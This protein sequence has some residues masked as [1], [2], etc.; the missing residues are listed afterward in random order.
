MSKSIRIRT[1]PGGNDKYVKVKLEQDFDF[2]EIL[3][4]KISQEEVYRKFCANYGVVAGRVIANNGF[5]VP[6]ARVSIFIPL[7]DDDSRDDLISGLYPFEN[8]T[9]TNNDGIRYNLLPKDSQGDCHTPVGTMSSKREILDNDVMV[10]I[11]EKYYKFTTIT[12]KSGDFMIF[13]VPTGYH[14]LHMDVDISDI[15]P[16]SQRPYDLTKQ[17]ANIKQFESP[18][19]FKGSKNLDSLAQIKSTNVGVNV[20]PFWGDEDNCEVG[21]SRV[22]INIPYLFEPSAIFMGS[23]FSDNDKHSINKHCRPRKKLGRLCETVT[24]QGTI[25]MI[26]ETLDGSVERFDVEGGRVIDENGAWAYQIPMNLDYMITDEFGNLIPSE[27]PTKGVPTRANVRFRI[28]MDVAGDEGRLRTRGKYL[29]PNNPGAS[30]TPDY[31]F[32]E[33]SPKTHFFNLKWNKVYTVR[34]LISRYQ[35]RA[36]GDNR[37]FIGIKNVDECGD[38]TPFP[39]NR[40]DTDFSPLYTVICFLAVTLA[41]IIWSI[42]SIVIFLINA[43]ISALNIVLKAICLAISSLGYLVCGL[44]HPF[45]GDKRDDCRSSSKWCI[46]TGSGGSCNCNS[47]LGYIKCITLTCGD[48]SY[49][50]GC[51]GNGLIETEKETY[52]VNTELSDYNNCIRISLGDA[53]DIFE[54]EFYNDWVNG[55][56]YLPLLK[57]KFK[58]KQDGDK[59]KFCEYDCDDY[60]STS[61]NNCR[62]AFILDTCEGG[63]GNADEKIIRYEINDG[64]VKK[65]GDEFY[66]VSTTHS[67]NKALYPTDITVLG[68]TLECDIDNFPIIHQKL[69]PTTYNIPEI[70]PEGSDSDE[71]GI[72]PLFFDNVTCLNFNISATNCENISKA[73]ELGVDLGVDGVIGNDDINDNLVRQQ[74]IGMNDGISDFPNI[75]DEF[76]GIDY[77]NYRGK[78]LDT[79]ILLVPRNNS[80]FFYFGIVP[81]KT[82]LDIAN[83]NFFGDCSAPQVNDFI[84][85]AVIS[86]VTTIGG[87]DGEITVS[88]VGGVSPFQYEWNTGDNTA[89][90]SNLSIGTYSVTVTDAEGLQGTASFTVGGS[91]PVS[92]VLTPKSVSQNGSSDGEIAVD[93]VTGGEAPYVAEIVSPSA[94]NVGTT[95]NVVNGSALFTGLIAGVYN[96]EVT[97]NLSES[98]TISVTVGEPDA[99][100]VTPSKVDILCRGAATGQISLNISGGELPYTTYTTGP[101]G[102]T[103]NTFVQTDLIAGT[104]SISVDDSIGQSTTQNVTISQPSSVVSFTTTV[105]QIQCNG[106]TGSITINASG[107]VGNYQYSNDGGTT[108]QTSNTFS[109]LGDGIY[110]ITVKDGN[111]CAA[112][113]VEVELVNPSIL[114]NNSYAG[115]GTITLSASGGWGGYTFKIG[116]EGYLYTDGETATSY[117]G[118]SPIP[119]GN[120]SVYVKDS[121]GCVKSKVVTVS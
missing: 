2:I 81:G 59:E 96:I 121:E 1:T 31:T 8:V 3:S 100:I 75:N 115:T 90:I 110:S 78:L 88:V 15:G 44:L 93:L 60:D 86:D 61:D 114:N 80:F 77:V 5:G 9:D 23:L 14:V 33:Q 18:T 51:S 39:Y 85:D 87:S 25:E 82:A 83:I 28:G 109:S 105:S 11:Y 7:S 99:L 57:Y 112:S 29:V 119:A 117:L 37:N 22:D 107:G 76:T 116:N 63:G 4:L 26:R 73:C 111:D 69:L 102:Y 46:G 19:K 120:Y 94:S 92:F 68:S 66:Y 53:L 106:G 55:T 56:L 84:I 38:H 103:A 118:T 70:I 34:N 71:I 16:L 49:A 97:D 40:I 47:V 79:S 45:N 104:Y 58:D 17:G 108:W 13:G 65:V 113:I 41:T 101:G 62:R 89:T 6:N 64:L 36:G 67:G 20:Q 43:L 54:F 27:D 52:P 98:T 48:L 30:D 10:E 24:G 50:P 91:I 32:N 42:N 35:R 12:N 95:Q 74:L 21:I 72:E